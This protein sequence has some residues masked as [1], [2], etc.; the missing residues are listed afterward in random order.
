MKVIFFRMLL[1]VM[2]SFS[3]V[4]SISLTDLSH[5]FTLT[6]QEFYALEFSLTQEILTPEGKIGS[7]KRDYHNLSEIP[8]RG[9]PLEYRLYDREDN[10]LA[11]TVMRS[12]LDRIEMDVLDAEGNLLGTIKKSVGSL[13]TSFDIQFPSRK[14]IEW[15]WNYLHKYYSLHYSHVPDNLV[16][17]IKVASFSP[18]AQ[19]DLLN[20]KA[21]EKQQL[22]PR[23]LLLATT[24]ISEI[25]VIETTWAY[26]KTTCPNV[27]DLENTNE[28]TPGTEITLNDISTGFDLVDREWSFDLRFDILTSNGKLGTVFRDYYKHTLT[29]ELEYI[30]YDV[31]ESVLAKAKVI[32]NSQGV[33][34]NV[35]DVSGAS[36]GTIQEIYIN[37]PHTLLKRKFFITSPKG[38]VFQGNWSV[39]KGYYTLAPVSDPKATFAHLKVPRIVYWTGMDVTNLSLLEEYALHPHLLILATICQY[40]EE[41]IR[42][43]WQEH[44]KSEKKD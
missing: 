34:I 42:D 32:F 44:L 25:S 6:P 14:T 1:F 37:S 31:A 5:G 10:L 30:L 21:M 12:F 4:Y 27:E 40:D 41:L 2:I 16:A 3:N 9:I 36:L 13:F 38:E 29:H 43:K 8:Y 28:T 26:T 7:I 20:L 35:T 23:V 33:E 22:D 17:R 39:W 15:T 19:S 11:K 18:W 24:F